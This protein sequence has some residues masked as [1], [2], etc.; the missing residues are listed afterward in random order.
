MMMDFFRRIGLVCSRIPEGKV[1]TYGQLALL[2]G[3]PHCARQAGRAL[4]TGASE[5]A[6]RVV[7][8]RGFLSGAEAFMFD[9]AQRA[10]LEEEGVTVSE[11]L[12]VD[13]EKY[14][15]RP[16]EE[17]ERQLAEAFELLGI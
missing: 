16:D 3:K 4:S 15:W 8:S 10:L 14:G 2:C 17:L 6:H 12:T 7:N 9:G 1:A 5:K 11:E 13:L